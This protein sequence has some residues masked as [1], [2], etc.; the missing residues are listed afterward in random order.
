MTAGNTSF[1]QSSSLLRVPLVPNTPG[2]EHE[3]MLLLVSDMYRFC[4]DSWQEAENPWLQH[5]PPH[6]TRLET[7]RIPGGVKESLALCISMSK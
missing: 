5:S 3:V 1:A 7:V 4:S 2:C 6:L